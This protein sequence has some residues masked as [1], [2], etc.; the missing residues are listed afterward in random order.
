MWLIYEFFYCLG[1]LAYL[2]RAL[3]RRRLPHAGWSMRLGRYPKRV[4]KSLG[5]RRPVWLHAVSVGEVLATRPLLRAL[6]DERPETPIVVSTITPAGF[7]VAS[8]QP[9]VIPIYFP[10]D[11]R[12]PVRRALSS[13]NP[14][15]LL[16][17][18]SELWPNALCEAEARN[19]PIAVV[20][21]RLSPRAFARY[22]IARPWAAAMLKRVTLFLMQS[23]ADADRMLAIGAP[24][25]RV[26]VTGSLKWDASLSARPDPQAVAAAAGKLGL[27]RDSLVI[28]AGSTHRGEEAL[29]LKAAETLRAAHPGL[30]LILAPRH[31]ER[32]D[33]VEA[34]VRQAGWRPVRTSRLQHEQDWDAA[35]VDSFGQLPFY[36]AMAT[37]IVIGGS[38]IPHGG[39]NPLEATSLGKPVVFGPSMHNFEAIAHQLLAHH[40]ARQASGAS[41]LPG[42]LAELLEHPDEARKM[43]ARAQT[44]T[45]E[46]QGATGRT[47]ELLKHTIS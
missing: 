42:L 29:V 46:F 28:V 7:D 24:A 32:L 14:I 34:L 1:F 19:I 3:W 26:R 41:E 44:L 37:A 20:N 13:L 35:I 22:Q 27:T 36:Y 47:M 16:L 30:R 38:F 40:T 8:Q 23:Q 45:E 39:Q 6:A 4:A 2:P 18:E 5:G 21:G 9:G 11:L 31:I 25:Q 12:G 15:C 10:L 43:G 33:E 17:L